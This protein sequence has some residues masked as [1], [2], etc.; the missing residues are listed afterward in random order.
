[1]T[2]IV[3]LGCG[4]MA[5]ALAVPAS[6]NEENEVHLIGS[7]LDDD[8]VNSIQ[9]TGLHPNLN[10]SIA[11][12]IST[13]FNSDNDDRRLREADVIIL[14][15]SSPGIPWALS[16]MAKAAARPRT[17]ALVTKGLV[18]S[19]NP[20]AAPLTYADALDVNLSTPAGRL[21]GIGG[22]CI[23]RELALRIP[24]RVTFASRDISLARELRSQ[25]QTEYYRITCSEDI[26]GLALADW[27][28]RNSS[29]Q[30]SAAQFASSLSSSAFDLAGMGDLHVTVGGGRNSRL[31]TLLGTGEKMSSLLEGP[32]KG[33][34]VEGVDTGRSLASSF[35]Q[36]CRLGKL[37]PKRFPLTK[38]ILDCI[39]EDAAF[40]LSFSNLA[41]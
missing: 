9:K 35:E 5:T 30:A 25:L 19:D 3:L 39:V 6:E 29:D 2:Q 40:E 21:V 27:L 23:A 38:A 33:V 7:P 1:M 37:D 36:S 14:G 11:T 4:V 12:K 34:T 22:P 32:M 8:I 13:Q 20:G 15:V 16:R 41:D 17:L 28:R 26:V 24:T 18:E 10:V 31:G